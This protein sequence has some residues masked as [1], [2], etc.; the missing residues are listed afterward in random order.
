MDV[1]STDSTAAGASGSIGIVDVLLDVALLG[2][3]GSGDARRGGEDD[4]L[5][6]DLDERDLDP[7]PAIDDDEEVPD[8][9]VRDLFDALLPKYRTLPELIRDGI[10]T[11]VDILQST[12]KRAVTRQAGRQFVIK[13]LT[14]LRQAVERDP[15]GKLE[16]MPGTAHA[17][18]LR[19]VILSMH[20]FW[21]A[22]DSHVRQGLVTRSQERGQIHRFFRNDTRELTERIAAARLRL[23][24]GS[25]VHRLAAA[26]AAAAAE[27]RGEAGGGSGSILDEDTV[28]TQ[29]D[30]NLLEIFVE[31]SVSSRAYPPSFPNTRRYLDLLDCVRGILAARDEPRKRGSKRARDGDE[32]QD[33]GMVSVLATAEAASAAAPQVD[34][35]VQEI[36]EEQLDLT[37]LAF[38]DVTEFTAWKLALRTR[39]RHAGENW[40]GESEAMSPTNYLHTF[41]AMLAMLCQ[42]G[43]DA[44]ALS[45]AELLVTLLRENLDALPSDAKRIRLAY[46]L[47]ILSSL[48]HESETALLNS[49]VDAAGNGIEILAPFYRTDPGRYAA[50][51]A[52]LKCC[53]ATALEDRSFDF[54][55]EGRQATLRKACR[56]ADDAVRL[57]RTQLEGDPSNM[58]LKCSLARA[59]LTRAEM[60]KPLAQLLLFQLRNAKCVTSTVQSKVKELNEFGEEEDGEDD[61]DESDFGDESQAL[62]QDPDARKQHEAAIAAAEGAV[63]LFRELAVDNPKLYEHLLA[64]ALE[65][66]ATLIKDFSPLE[67]VAAVFA[68]TADLS[69]GETR[70]FPGQ[71]HGVGR[72][73]YDWAGAHRRRGDLAGAAH[74][75]QRGVNVYDGLSR[76]TAGKVMLAVSQMDWV[77]VVGHAV[78]VFLQLERYEEGLAAAE[79]SLRMAETAG[80]ESRDFVN[81]A[82]GHTGRGICLFMLG[83]FYEARRWLHAASQIDENQERMLAQHRMDDVMMPA[84]ARLVLTLAHLG[85]AQSSL[86]QH[87]TAL[88]LGT[89]A[90][91]RMRER[92]STTKPER[93]VRTLMDNGRSEASVLPRVLLLQAATLVA[94]DEMEDAQADLRECI[95]LSGQAGSP[96]YDAATV[97]TALL[98]LAKVLEVGEGSEAEGEGHGDAAAARRAREQAEAIGGVRGFL[99]RLGC[100][101]KLGIA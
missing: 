99:A 67:E 28:V 26:A 37:R 15:H 75:L 92:V 64:S 45:F 71:I 10:R 80:R 91:K 70:A 48:L 98:L 97:K 39:L 77:S 76:S 35:I 33:E 65:L 19:S 41:L 96:A 53:Y 42:A 6:D 23:G 2:G 9:P 46:A 79:V 12:E 21:D 22:A 69:E 60:G 82:E 74:A 16:R 59:F 36:L 78:E 55:G 11:S 72:V 90:L 20:R 32:D 14:F 47:A 93:L 40:R 95:E 62:A 56:H 18:L 13:A 85:A 3:R 43:L 52:A 24:M 58:S 25:K 54:K 29:I 66:K 57:Y 73:Y 101:K 83:R 27:E 31:M 50:P 4:D 86:G 88:T 49:M 81:E 38:E 7:P 1:A 63:A 8:G 51:L 68:E 94:L 30:D 100:A 87:R 61:D 34:P 17:L 5:E 89:K 84:G 44:T